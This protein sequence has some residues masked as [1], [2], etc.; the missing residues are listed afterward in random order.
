MWKF[1]AHY[2]NT[3]SLWTIIETELIFLIIWL[4]TADTIMVIMDLCPQI[5]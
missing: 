1:I 4:I 2:Q 3:P 5:C